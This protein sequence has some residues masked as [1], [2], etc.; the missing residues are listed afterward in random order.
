M[1]LFK[2]TKATRFK[3]ETMYLLYDEKNDF[4][5][6]S[7]GYEYTDV[8]GNVAGWCW[9]RV[10]EDVSHYCDVSKIEKEG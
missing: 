1:S 9:N 8:Y 6:L 7:T 5:F 3:E 4:Y 10:Y 2:I